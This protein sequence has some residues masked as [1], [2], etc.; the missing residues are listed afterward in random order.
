M[1]RTHKAFA[2]VALIM[3]QSASALGVVNR[4]VLVTGSTDGIGITTAKHLAKKGYDVLIHGRDSQRI[5]AA[6]K[7]VQS[8]GCQGKVL[9]LPPA[10]L[11]TLQGCRHLVQQV[12]NLCDAENLSLSILMNNAGVFAE[13]TY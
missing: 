11:S 2:I 13:S 5:E 3:T 6:V 12:E 4:A 10:D 1:I 7:A 8:F 9:S